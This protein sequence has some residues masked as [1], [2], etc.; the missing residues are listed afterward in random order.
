MPINIKSKDERPGQ[1]AYSEDQRQ[2]HDRTKEMPNLASRDR[3]KATGH[4]LISVPKRRDNHIRP[5]QRPVD[6]P[7]QT[8]VKIHYV[9]S[10][11]RIINTDSNAY[12]CLHHHKSGFSWLSLGHHP[13]RKPC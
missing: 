4:K 3:L 8:R 10:S 1:H 5:S 13:Q 11:Y 7:D 12:L 2:D 9:R 6:I